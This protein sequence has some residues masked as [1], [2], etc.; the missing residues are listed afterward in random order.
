MSDNTNKNKGT[1]FEDYLKLVVA[2]LVIA[3]FDGPE[4]EPD[5]D[6]VRA[7]YN[8]GLSPIK[9]ANEFITNWRRIAADGVIGLITEEDEE[10]D[11]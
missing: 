10:E 4:N 8:K 6:E 9:C 5:E 7:D 1:N 2:E 11:V 3:G